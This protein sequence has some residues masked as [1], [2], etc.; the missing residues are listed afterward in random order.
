[1]YVPKLFQ[2]T[3]W[4]EIK[5]V[6]D[7]NSFATVVSCGA[8]GP[9]ATHLPLR[10]VESGPEKWSLQG[11]VSRANQHWRLFGRDE[12]SL[13]MF[14]GPN[15]YVSPRWYDHVNVPTWNYVAVHVYGKARVVDD[16]AELRTLM[17]G[18]VDRYEGHVEPAERYTVE[19]LPPDYLASQMKGIVGFEISVDEVQ[20]SFKLSQNRDEKNHS[21]VIGELRKSEDQGALGVA[22]EMVCRRPGSGVKE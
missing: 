18:L 3:N 19:K 13:A 21:S 9:V 22:Q 10:L 14:T 17:E 1:M 2:E 6:I 4:S 15:A 12:R 7:Q 20:A 5:R 11:H 8:E 16:P